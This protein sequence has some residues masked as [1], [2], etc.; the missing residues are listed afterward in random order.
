MFQHV[1][2]ATNFSFVSFLF[3]RLK[4]EI[5]KDLK[6]YFWKIDKNCGSEAKSCGSEAKSLWLGSQVIV[7]RKPSHCG[8]EAKSLWL[9]SQVIVA[10]N[11]RMFVLFYIQQ[12]AYLYVLSTFTMSLLILQLTR[13][14]ILTSPSKAVLTFLLKSAL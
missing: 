10:R 7:A 13:K 8:S 12:I 14:P 3:L 11:T 6:E 9:G 5:E 1:A 4:K 2:S